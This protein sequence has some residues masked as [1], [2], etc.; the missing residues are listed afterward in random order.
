MEEIET[1]V[2]DV[3]EVHPNCTVII[4]KNSV[5]GEYSIGWYDNDE[6]PV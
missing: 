5:T 1:N 4:W 3:E 6:E 2:F